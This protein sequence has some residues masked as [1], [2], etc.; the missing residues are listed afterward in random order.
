MTAWKRWQD[1]ATMAFG[2]L[3]FISPFVFGETSHQK[4]T[5]A[6]YVL[7]VLLFA[8]GVVAAATKEARRSLIV[9]APGFAAVITFV[10]ALVL[11]FT[12]AATGIVWTAVVMAVLTVA[13]GATLRLGQ[14]D[15]KAA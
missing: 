3:L 10:A 6:A 8:S 12:S 5:I 14:A 13:V 7:G 1:Y 15:T 11:L 9:N 4:S 2:V